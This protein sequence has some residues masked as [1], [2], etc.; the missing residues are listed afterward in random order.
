MQTALFGGYAL[1]ERGLILER[2]NKNEL[3]CEQGFTFDPVTT[4]CYNIPDVLNADPIDG[5]P[6]LSAS[7]SI[8]FDSDDEVGGFMDLLTSGENK[9]IINNIS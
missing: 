9:F 6:I 3:A 8:H 7:D 5:C 4:R 1:C 2:I